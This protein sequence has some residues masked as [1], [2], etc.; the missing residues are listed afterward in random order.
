MKK[1]KRGDVLSPR[2]NAKN[3]PRKCLTAGSVEQPVTYPVRRFLGSWCRPTASCCL[4]QAYTMRC[5]QGK[6]WTGAERVLLVLQS[7]KHSCEGNQR[8]SHREGRLQL[9]G[10]WYSVDL[11]GTLD[12]PRK[13][14]RKVTITLNIREHIE[15]TIQRYS[16]IFNDIQRY[17]TN[18]REQMWRHEMGMKACS[19]LESV[20]W[21]YY[22]GTAICLGSPSETSHKYSRLGVRGFPMVSHGFLAAQDTLKLW[23]SHKI[24]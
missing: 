21:R 12:F 23:K 1:K 10:L 19:M 17:S 3:A 8:W 15:N 18:W 4:K 24:T 11:C 6:G 20:E 2:F 7:A 22:A 13:V 16:T 5:S 14:R 9:E